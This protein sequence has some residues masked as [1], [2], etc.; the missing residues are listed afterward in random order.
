MSCLAYWSC[1]SGDIYPD[2]NT[3]GNGF[4]LTADFRFADIATFPSDYDILFGTFSG[5]SDIPLVSKTISK[6]SGNETVS[7]LLSNIPDNSEFIRLTLA[8]PGRKTVYVFFEQQINGDINENVVIP[9][10][11]IRLIQYGRIQE[12]VFSQ[13][14]ACHGGSSE[15]G[16]ALNLTAERSYNS[17]VDKPSS[18]QPAKKRV[19]PGNVPGSFLIDVLTEDTGLNYAH[20]TGISSLKEDDIILLKEW[21]KNGAHNE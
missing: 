8:K 6:P 17:L 1:D 10:Q 2:E 20:N 21:I 9:E 12:Q 5:E 19:E 16:G 3:G 15:A 7:V 14:I 13:C 11:N 4:S 18:K